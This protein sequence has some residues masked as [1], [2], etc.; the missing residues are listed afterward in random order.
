MTFKMSLIIYIQVF[1]LLNVKFSLKCKLL[2]LE[3]SY[4]IIIIY[5][6]NYIFFSFFLNDY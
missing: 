2:I 6:K 1:I 5:K 4:I 3:F